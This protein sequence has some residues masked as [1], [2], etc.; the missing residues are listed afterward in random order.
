MACFASLESQPDAERSQ[1]EQGVMP[2][3]KQ[4]A[5]ASEPRLSSGEQHHAGAEAAVSTRQRVQGAIKTS[6][7]KPTLRVPSLGKAETKSNTKQQPDGFSQL[8]LRCLPPLH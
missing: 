1:A 2:R 7:H 5:A 8:A 6:H 4:F 3:T